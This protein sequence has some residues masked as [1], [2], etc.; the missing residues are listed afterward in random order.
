MGDVIEAFLPHG[1]FPYV[2]PGTKYVTLGGMA[3]A[4]VHGKNHHLDGGFG[5]FVTWIEVMG[6]DGSITRASP[7][8]NAE[9]F[10]WT[11]GGMGLTGVITRLALRLRPVTT[12]WIQQYTHPGAQPRSRHGLV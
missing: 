1:W 9:L 7:Q 11:I 8:D 4:D 5:N 2:T 12:G 6:P 10:H 3:A